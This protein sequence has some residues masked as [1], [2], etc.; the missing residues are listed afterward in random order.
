MHKTVAVL[1]FSGQGIQTGEKIALTVEASGSR[2]EKRA[3]MR[4]AAGGWKGFSTLKEEMEKLILH[5]DVFVF[6]GAAAIAVRAVAPY[7]CD[8]LKDPAVL[9][10]D[11]C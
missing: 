3:P 10:V 5:A 6:V 7:V 8:K 2:V 9:S 1:A 11:E 4:L